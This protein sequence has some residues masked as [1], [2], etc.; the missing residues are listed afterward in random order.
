[1]FFF[2]SLC[3]HWCYWPLLL[4]LICSF[5]C[6][7]QMLVYIHPYNRLFLT[8]IVCLYRHSDVRPWA[9]SLSFLSSGS[10]VEVLCSSILRMLPII[11]Q[12]GH[13]IPATELGFEMSSRIFL[14]LFSYFFFHFRLFNGVHF[15]YPQVL[16]IL[17]F[18]ERSNSFLTWLFYFLF[19]FMKVVKLKFKVLFI[20]IIS[21]LYHIYSF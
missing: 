19:Q 13:G 17:L 8:H 20:Y 12:E 4:V 9:L 5:E 10:F 7:L 16:V 21:D 1:M 14:I 15:Y 2:L 18:S 3:C 11:L 6:P